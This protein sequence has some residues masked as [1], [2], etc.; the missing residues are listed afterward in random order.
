MLD[1]CL[2][3]F[4]LTDSVSTVV[5]SIATVYIRRKK[6]LHNNAKF[7]RRYDRNMSKIVWSSNNILWTNAF[8]GL[9]VIIKLYS[10]CCNWQ[11]LWKSTGSPFRIDT[12][13]KNVESKCKIVNNLSSFGLRS[14]VDE[15]RRNNRNAIGYHLLVILTWSKLIPLQIIIP[16]PKD[17]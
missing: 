12:H 4:R 15:I 11:Y 13:T 2:S 3:S 6:P 17:W 14:L 1:I 10:E 9:Y 16:L 5:K 8:F 7:L